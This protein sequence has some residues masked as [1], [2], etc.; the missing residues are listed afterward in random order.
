[1]GRCRWLLCGSSLVL[2]VLNTVLLFFV[3]SPS[4]QMITKIML[5]V[6]GDVIAILTF[7]LGVYTY[8]KNKQAERIRKT[9]EDFPIV[10]NDLGNLTE[11]LGV[12]FKSEQASILKDYAVKMDRFAVGVNNGAYDLEIINQMSGGV[13]IQH[14]MQYLAVYIAEARKKNAGKYVNTL[15]I[16]SN[17]ETMIQKLCKL[18]GV[19]KRGN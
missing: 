10:R 18:R 1:M 14:Y 6:I 12:C 2:L 9:I 7:G 13:L 8:K 4:T 17:Y 15:E 3:L 16:Y 5:S 11:R 19:E